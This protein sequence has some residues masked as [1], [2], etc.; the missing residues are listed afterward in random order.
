MAARPD[1]DG[2]NPKTLPTARRI[3]DIASGYEPALI[4]EAAIVEVVPSKVALN[5]LGYA[6]FG[7][8]L[9]VNAVRMVANDTSTCAMEAR[10]RDAS[11]KEIVA[12]VA[13]REA[14][15]LAVVSVR[16][17]TWYSNAE[18]IIT[19]WSQQLVQVANRKPGETVKDVDTFTLKPW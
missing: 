6:P 4:L 9:T 5:A 10:I 19:Q 16:G 7:I 15:Q 12:T 18:T 1:D 11:T 13:D 17:L 3:L 8:G 2:Q 14:Q